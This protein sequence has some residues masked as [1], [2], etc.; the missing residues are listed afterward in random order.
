MRRATI[1]RPSTDVPT[2][3][4]SGGRLV[5]G[6]VRGSASAS[7]CIRGVAVSGTVAAGA[8]VISRVGMLRA[9]G[10]GGRSPGVGGGE[11]DRAYTCGGL[12]TRVVWHPVNIMSMI[13]TTN[14]ILTI[15]MSA[16]WRL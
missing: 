13:T 12:T 14:E 7:G 4:T 16:G 15:S 8:A 11:V 5:A 10:V 1:S 9:A 6:E 3:I 2:R